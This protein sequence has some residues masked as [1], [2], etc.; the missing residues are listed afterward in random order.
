M[1]T[2]I[3][4]GE[5]LDLLLKNVEQMFVCQRSCLCESAKVGLRMSMSVEA[6]LLVL[7]LET[8]KARWANYLPLHELADFDFGKW[9]RKVSLWKQ[10]LEEEYCVDIPGEYE[11]FVPS[12]EYLF[13]LYGMVQPGDSAD[14]GKPARFYDKCP[15]TDI[16]EDTR[17][18]VKRVGHLIRNLDMIKDQQWLT[19][20]I[21]NAAVSRLQQA[22]QDD[23]GETVTEDGVPDQTEVREG[24]TSILGNMLTFED[25]DRCCIHVLGDLLAVLEQLQ[26]L[27]FTWQPAEMFQRLG[28]R[29]YYHLCTESHRSAIRKA[30]ELKNVWPEGKVVQYALK[31]KEKTKARL[32]K[33]WEEKGL[34]EYVDLDNPSLTGNAQF[35]RFLYKNRHELTRDDIRS[36]HYHCRLILQLNKM[37]EEEQ[38]V[39]S[40]ASV[41]SLDDADTGIWIWLKKSIHRPGI[42]WCNITADQFETVMAQALGIRA[43]AQVPADARLTD[44]LWGLFHYRRGCNAVQ[45][46]LVTWLNI[47]GFLKRNG[48]VEGTAP[49]LLKAFCPGRDKSLYNNITK[50][51]GGTQ[52]NFE[53]VTVLLGRY[54]GNLAA[55]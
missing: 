9:K 51:V 47:V 22:M 45:S 41:R 16:Q 34:S 28:I 27:T 29:Q 53:E 30:I 21:T 44:R 55:R 31:E 4:T 13:D 12:G 43:C 48:Y 6:Q 19:E 52:K 24:L 54:L 39:G 20:L 37:V 2:T 15:G 33:T 26:D 42:P 1:K 38:P 49:Q 35:G 40:S 36:I 25:S 50:G 32:Q 17:Q 3:S 11:A 14:G 5:E 10:I 8:I 46:L 18:Y 7:K 23:L